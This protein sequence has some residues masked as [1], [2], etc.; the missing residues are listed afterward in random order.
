MIPIIDIAALF[1]G[2]TTA[3]AAADRAIAA[4]AMDTG[5]MVVTGLPD[6]VPVTPAHLQALKRIFALDPALLRPLCRQKFEPGNPNVY[7]GWFPLQPG[8]KTY[9][10]GIDIGPDLAH[11]PAVVAA[12]DPLREATPLPSEAALPGWRADAAAYYRGMEHTGRMLMRA[13]AR[14]LGLAET[15]FDAAFEGGVSTFRLIH[16]PARAPEDLAAIADPGVW[17][18]HNGARAYMSGEAHVDSGLVTLLA[19]DGVSGLQAKARDGGWID[20]PPL[21]RSLVINF[22]RLLERWTGGRIKATEHRVIGTGQER[23]SVPFFY[24]PR[25]EAVIA[26]LSPDAPAFEPFQ[27]GDH[28][29]AS[30]MNFVEFAGLEH[31]RPSRALREELARSQVRHAM[32]G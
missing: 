4:A 2:D 7:R 16:Y 18:E 8:H 10:E 20:V 22:G 12:G 14:S 6:A 21:D 17:V 11:G 28:V 32:A 31:L 1:E 13:L 15:V 24:E 25:A 26:P 23:Y 19:Q 29:W 9:K 30:M 3:R 5:F 27:Y